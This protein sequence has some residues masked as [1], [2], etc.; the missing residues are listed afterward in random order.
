MQV[1]FC[2][3]TKLHAPFQASVM[4]CM[5]SVL[6]WDVRQCRVVIPCCCFGETYQSHLQQSTNFLTLEECIS[7]NSTLSQKCM[8][9]K[10]KYSNN[11]NSNGE[12]DYFTAH[13]ACKIWNWSM[14]F[15][16]NSMEEKDCMS[17]RP[18][19]LHSVKISSQDNVS[20]V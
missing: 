18:S 4:M 7:H 8:S 13:H 9:G 6:F 12:N 16:L 2:T 11:N 10:K 17:L 14:K 1:T 19:F 3:A 15:K 20:T 5:R